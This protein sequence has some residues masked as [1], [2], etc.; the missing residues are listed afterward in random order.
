MGITVAVVV[1]NDASPADITLEIE[2]IVQ[3]NLLPFRKVEK[4]FF[5]RESTGRISMN[6]VISSSFRSS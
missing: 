6:Q 5:T 2:R 3:T 1:N 4:N